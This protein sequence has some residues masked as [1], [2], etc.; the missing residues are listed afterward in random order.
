MT[1]HNLKIAANKEDR[2]RLH[3]AI[4]SLEESYKGLQEAAFPLSNDYLDALMAAIWVRHVFI[5]CAWVCA[6]ASIVALFHAS[7]H[8]LLWAAACFLVYRL[9]LAAQRHNEVV[10]D[11]MK[12]ASDEYYRAVIGGQLLQT[13]Y[14]LRSYLR[15]VDNQDQIVFVDRDGVKWTAADIAEALLKTSPEALKF[16]CAC[17]IFGAPQEGERI[18]EVASEKYIVVL[19][20]LPEE[21]QV[22]LERPN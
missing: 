15:N 17:A 11:S 20:D 4:A 7:W 22:S 10:V 18:Q 14:L 8:A 5:V 19:E 1:V 9:W 21:Q 6:V 16:I 12:R 3:T 13:A 2:A